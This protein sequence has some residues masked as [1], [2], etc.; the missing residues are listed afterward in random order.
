[1]FALNIGNSLKTARGH[2]YCSQQIT[3]TTIQEIQLSRGVGIPFT[4]ITPPLYGTCLKSGSGFP[5][6]Y[7][8][9][10]F[11]FSE[12]SSLRFTYGNIDMDNTE[13]MSMISRS[14]L[15]SQRK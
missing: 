8:M 2:E 11:V 14:Q 5:T 7:V 10:F 13:A 9:V 1:M 3:N 6:L 15:T 4:D 12:F